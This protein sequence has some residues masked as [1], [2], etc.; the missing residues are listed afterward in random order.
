MVSS[1]R[2][3]VPAF[4][5]AALQEGLMRAMDTA[6]VGDA[7]MTEP[8]GKRLTLGAE[9]FFGVFKPSSRAVASASERAT[10]EKP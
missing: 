9:K 6:V 8:S 3:R 7:R 10:T 1:V 2:G 4:P 5:S